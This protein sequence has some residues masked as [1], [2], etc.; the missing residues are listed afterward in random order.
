MANRG[1]KRVEASLT[2]LKRVDCREVHS[3]SVSVGAS[4]LLEV[5]QACRACVSTCPPI[6]AP[7]L[8]A[9]FSWEGYSGWHWRVPESLA[10][11]K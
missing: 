11:Q 8:W 5:C 6:Q 4:E 10:R 9:A 2:P 1:I 3:E 7:W